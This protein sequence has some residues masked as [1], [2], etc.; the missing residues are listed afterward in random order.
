MV[1]WLALSLLLGARVSTSA[2]APALINE[3]PD[4]PVA[5]ATALLNRVVPSNLVK[6]FRLELIPPANNTA[7][8]AVGVMQ[9]SS[10]TT[11][12]VILRGSGGVEIASALNWYMNDYL[13]IT[14]DWAT[15]AE[16][17]QQ[18]L[19]VNDLRIPFTICMTMVHSFTFFAMPFVMEKV[20][21][22]STTFEGSMAWNWSFPPKGGG[23]NF[24][25]ASAACQRNGPATPVGTIVLHERV[26][27]RIFTRMVRLG[28]LAKA[29]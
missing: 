15:Y 8:E 12:T 4:D 2:V 21:N 16:V 7:G 9:L 23:G 1:A 24:G 11:G 22:I 13:N 14:F 19:N 29:Y 28:L 20:H 3:Y 27:S 26:H 6:N 18:I 10:D 5:A 17:R 25:A